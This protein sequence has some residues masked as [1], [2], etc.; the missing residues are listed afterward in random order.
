M[1]P[2][3]LNHDGDDSDTEDAPG[4]GVARERGRAARVRVDHWGFRVKVIVDM[5]DVHELGI[6]FCRCQA[7][8]AGMPMDEQLIK[9]GG[10]FPASQ[11]NPRTCFT[12]RG[13][14]YHR[15]DRLECKIAPQ[16]IMRKIRRFTSELHPTTVPVCVYV[17]ILHADSDNA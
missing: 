14:D 16:A 17:F 2:V 4:P 1:A 15:L 11:K 13:L 9:L 3:V 7:G 6:A 5:A 8:G 10:L 12:L